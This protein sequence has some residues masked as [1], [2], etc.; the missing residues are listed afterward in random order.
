MVFVA[1]GC[2]SYRGFFSEAEANH[3]MM[4]QDEGL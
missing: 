2:V 1:A 3:F 4:N